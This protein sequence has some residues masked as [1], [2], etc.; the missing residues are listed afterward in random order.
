[1][2]VQYL[3]VLRHIGDYRVPRYGSV[4]SHPVRGGLGTQEGQGGCKAEKRPHPQ[5]FA[6]KL[7]GQGLIV[8]IDREPMV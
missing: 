3:L 4:G 8:G 6:T 7:L 1:M 5:R 2:S